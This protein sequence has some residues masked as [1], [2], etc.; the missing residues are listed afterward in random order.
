MA[1]GHVGREE[2]ERLGNRV[3]RVADQYRV[4]PVVGGAEHLGHQGGLLHLLRHEL[5]QRLAAG[6]GVKVQGDKGLARDPGEIGRTL[7]VAAIGQQHMVEVLDEVLR[8]EVR[9]GHDAR[10]VGPL[11]GRVAARRHGALEREVAEDAAGSEPGELV[12]V[13]EVL[14]PPGVEVEVADALLGDAPEDELPADLGEPLAAEVE[15]QRALIDADRLGEA[16]LLPGAAGHVTDEAVV[17]ALEVREAD[18]EPRGEAAEVGVLEQHAGLRGV[19][20]VDGDD[21]VVVALA[22]ERVGA[23]DVDVLADEAFGADGGGIGAGLAQRPGGR[24]V[25]ELG[26][27]GFE[28]VGGQ[29]EPVAGFECRLEIRRLQV[30]FPALVVT[31]PLREV[32]GQARGALQ[33]D[34]VDPR[35]AR[36]LAR[37]PGLDGER[38]DAL[39]AIEREPLLALDA[40][41]GLAPALARTGVGLGVQRVPA[42]FGD[43]RVDDQAVVGRAVEVVGPVKPHHA[44]VGR[45]L[46]PGPLDP[47]PVLPELEARDAVAGDGP[48]L[49]FADLRIMERFDDSLGAVDGGESHGEGGKIIGS[50]MMNVEIRKAG[51]RTRIRFFPDFLSSTL[52]TIGHAELAGRHQLDHYLQTAALAGLL[53]CEPRLCRG[54]VPAEEAAVGLRGDGVEAAVA[55]AVVDG[56]DA[57]A[58][59]IEQGKLLDLDFDAFRDADLGVGAAAG[60]DDA[61]ALAVHRQ[62]GGPVEDHATA[63]LDGPIVGDDE[64]V[65]RRRIPRALPPREPALPAGRDIHRGMELHRVAGTDGLDVG[66]DRILRMRA[67]SVAPRCERGVTLRL[68][69]Q[70]GDRVGVIEDA[71]VEGEAVAG[72]LEDEAALVLV[73]VIAA[74]AVA[75]DEELHEFAGVAADGAHHA[76]VGHGADGCKRRAL[77][78]DLAVKAQRQQ[79]GR[80]A[81]AAEGL[82]V[83]RHPMRLRHEPGEEGEAL[84]DGEHGVGEQDHVLLLVGGIQHLGEPVGA[85]QGRGDERARVK[86]ATAAVER[87]AEEGL[88]GGVGEIRDALEVAPIGEEGL[89]EVV[90]EVEPRLVG[91]R[92]HARRGWPRVRVD[93]RRHGSLEEQQAVDPGR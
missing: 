10:R 79:H 24:G 32:G 48:L 62:A 27:G 66:E 35:V 73:L 63:L 91:V 78:R 76:C 28:L 67:P 86:A 88:A 53:E 23:P 90:L 51:T 42:T 56:V 30:L 52:F 12:A 17:P 39:G 77:G 82:A 31:L 15:D 69:Q 93:L 89:G 37:E 6:A 68:L 5:L 20:A 14:P 33:H 70:V 75:H 26:A 87:G 36:S 47:D 84:G 13:E 43:D 16:A 50:G 54:V 74:G 45:G 11:Q 21:L 19:G 8:R 2:G 60:D 85:Q 38:A 1:V 25:G 55:G 29:Q 3:H 81:G 22:A 44:A 9:V 71:E 4:L 18:G 46:L 7:D 64:G 34:P 41:E 80:G 58:A 59:R 65:G 92:G 72:V 49:E 83:D 57:Q 61:V 40:A